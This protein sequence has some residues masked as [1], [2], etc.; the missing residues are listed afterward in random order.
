MMEQK[1]NHW[2]NM[3][4][5]KSH[6]RTAVGMAVWMAIRRSGKSTYRL[7]KELQAD[8]I[9]IN[10]SVLDSVCDGTSFWRAA[11][12]HAARYHDLEQFEFM[13]ILKH[14]GIPARP[15]LV[16]WNRLHEKSTAT[17]VQNLHIAGDEA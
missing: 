5:D 15:A 3:M 1:S 12:D 17:T 13:A 10:P 4:A 9:S 11:F 14:C 6:Y 2:P 7:S 16:V 8:G